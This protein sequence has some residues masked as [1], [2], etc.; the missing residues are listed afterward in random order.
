MTQAY[1]AKQPVWSYDG[2]ARGDNHAHGIGYI[3][4]GRSLRCVY[5]MRGSKGK[6]GIQRQPIGRLVIVGKLYAVSMGL[7]VNFSG[8]C[9]THKDQLLAAFQKP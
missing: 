8:T 5:K 7:V 1:C 3:A 4:V 2:S 6:V 9:V